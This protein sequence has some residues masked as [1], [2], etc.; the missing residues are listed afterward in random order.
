MSNRNLSRSKT[1]HHRVLLISLALLGALKPTPSAGA[2]LLEEGGKSVRRGELARYS[3]T[4]PDGLSLRKIRRVGVGMTASGALGLAGAEIE[5]NFTPETSFV[6]GFGGGPGYQS[7]TLQYKTILS[8]RNFLPYFA[9]GYSRWYSTRESTEFRGGSTPSV[10]AERFLSVSERANGRFAV[11]LIHPTLGVQV[12]QPSGPWVGTSVFFE[13]IMLTEIEN[14]DMV[15][16]GSLGFM[17]Y[18]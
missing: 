12:I 18:F 11:N 16:T 10:L 1:L 15:P 8:G 6:G 13:L 5:L 3:K 7:F 2:I 4:A 17:Y 9:G 14:L